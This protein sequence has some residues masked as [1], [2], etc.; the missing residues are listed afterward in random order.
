MNFQVGQFWQYVHLIRANPYRHGSLFACLFLYDVYIT[1]KYSFLC[2]FFIYIFKIFSWFEVWY[3]SPLNTW[4]QQ[5]FGFACIQGG[6]TSKF[7]L[8][9]NIAF[10]YFGKRHDIKQ[11][12]AFKNHFLKT[13]AIWDTIL[14]LVES[15]HLKKFLIRSF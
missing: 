5:D 14:D 8:R 6:Q 9:K 15:G 11:C 1:S 7:K 2:P 10:Y 3:F 13:T 4:K 12:T